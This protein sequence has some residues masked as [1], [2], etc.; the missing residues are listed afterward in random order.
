MIT[1]LRS[2]RIMYDFSKFLDNAILADLAVTNGT[3]GF[4]KINVFKI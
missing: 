2:V 4:F 3:K 1:D